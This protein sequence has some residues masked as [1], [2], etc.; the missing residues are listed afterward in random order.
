MEN[1]SKALIIAGAIL[2]SILIIGLGMFIYNQAASSVSDTG[3]DATAI[4]SFN[5]QFRSY[6]GTS[7]SGT[8]VRALLNTIKTHNLANE[9]TSRR[10]GVESADV[11]KTQDDVATADITKAYNGIKTGYR[12]TVVMNYSETS[13]LINGVTI[14]E[15][16]SK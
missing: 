10:L 14:T 9:D 16:K 13:G 11:K 1:A 5:A 8:N 6:E 4:D 2:L 15:N 7:V 12:Y 3:L